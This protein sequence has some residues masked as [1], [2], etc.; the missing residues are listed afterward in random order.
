MHPVTYDALLMLL[1]FSRKHLDLAFS[2]FL[3]CHSILY[4]RLYV[5]FLILARMNVGGMDSRYD[6]DD[7]VN[8]LVC[9]DCDLCRYRYRYL[10][11]SRTLILNCSHRRAEAYD[12]YSTLNCNQFSVLLIGA[13][14]DV[15]KKK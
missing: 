14:S 10:S 9:F 5:H 13:V 15:A 2:A 6:P 7:V 8:G 1:A 12:I 3:A 4:Y 11:L